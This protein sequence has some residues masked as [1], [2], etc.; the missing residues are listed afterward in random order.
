MIYVPIDHKP[1]S[2][3]R[4]QRL[5]NI[6]HQPKISLLVDHYD[7]DWSKL[8]WV[9]VDGESEVSEEPATTSVAHSMLKSKY[10]Q[11]EAVAL[12]P[13]VI[14]IRSTHVASWSAT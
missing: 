5:T 12:E 7:V 2:G 1:K 4:L 10:P 9:R 3:N 8:W 6:A 11:Y 14:M 13:L